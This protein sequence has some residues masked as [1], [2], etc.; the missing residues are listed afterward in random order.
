MTI[1]EPLLYKVTMTFI[2]LKEIKIETS[3]EYQEERAER[4]S[5]MTMYERSHEDMMNFYK[6]HM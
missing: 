5:Q 2:K 4:R 1:M 3:K 6:R